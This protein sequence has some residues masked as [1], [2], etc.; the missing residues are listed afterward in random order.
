MTGAAH[1]RYA[2]ALERLEGAD[3]VALVMVRP[4][5]RLDQ[6]AEFVV[7]PLI[8]EVALL[9]GDPFLQPEMRLDDEFLLG[10]GA[11]LVTLRDSTAVRRRS[12]HRRSARGRRSWQLMVRPGAARRG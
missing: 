2:A 8:L 7:E 12:Q 11:L 1:V 9:L 3:L 4:A 6:L 5:G 10:H